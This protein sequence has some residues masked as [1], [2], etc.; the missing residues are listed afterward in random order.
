MAVTADE[1]VRLFG[2]AKVASEGV[3]GNTVSEDTCVDVLNTLAAMKIPLKLFI[4]GGLGDVPKNLKKFAKK[5][6]T[7]S[8]KTAAQKTID[9]WKVIMT[10]GGAKGE[11]PKED[12]KDD[13]KKA[14]DEE[15]KA[16]DDDKQDLDDSNKSLIQLLGPELGDPFRD[17]TRE[18]IAEALALC[19]GMEGVYASLKDCAQTASAVEKAMSN[20]WT[21]CGKEYKAK[22]RLLSFNL[23]DPK[24]PDLRRSV[25][26]GVIDPVT[27][28]DM[29]PEELGSIERRQSNNAIR[30]HATNEAVRGQKKEASTDAFKCGKCKQRKCTYYQLQTRSADE[31]MTTFVTCVNCDN[32]WKFC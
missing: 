18:L 4:S 1:V 3:E 29:S 11:A 26:D 2:K 21:D 19:V 12:A 10:G 9:A 5:G 15:K 24:N 7:D 8:I 16:D 22:F 27:L 13:E 17:R 28:L 6:P 30:E 20:R 32:R 25:A 14:N 31:P 23:K